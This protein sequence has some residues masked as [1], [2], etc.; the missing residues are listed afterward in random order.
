[1]HGQHGVEQLVQGEGERAV[2]HLE[3]DRPPALRDVEHRAGGDRG[4]GGEVAAR[5][6]QFGGGGEVAV[7]G[8]AVAQARGGPGQ[9]A[10]QVPRAQGE[11]GGRVGR[12]PRGVRRSARER[13]SP[14]PEKP[15]PRRAESR[16]SVRCTSRARRRS[17]V[18][19]I[20]PAASTT[21]GAV[22]TRGAAEGSDGV[23]VL[24]AYPPPRGSIRVT[25]ASVTARAPALSA[26]AR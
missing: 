17:A 7:A 3:P 4:P 15:S 13:K 21:R 22:H 6:A 8:A 5:G 1:M 12:S 9:R 20:A 26:A 11:L 23:V 18:V 25:S 10:A 2:L 14:L 16:G 24:T 19:A